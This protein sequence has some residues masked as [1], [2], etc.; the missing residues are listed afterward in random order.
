MYSFISRIAIVI[1]AIVIFLVAEFGT[2]TQLSAEVILPDLPEG[3]LYQLIFATAGQ[4]DGRS[5]DI[6][7]YNAFVAQQAALSSRLPSAT[8]CAVASTSTV[9]AK[10]NG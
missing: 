2:T 6:A 1:F 10:D 5:T 3:S 9:D 8:W 4:R 7:D